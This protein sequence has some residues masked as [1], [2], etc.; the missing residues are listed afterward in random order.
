MTG[1]ASEWLAVGLTPFVL[2]GAVMAALCLIALLRRT[3]FEG[4]LR[5]F[6]LLCLKL[7]T[8]PPRDDA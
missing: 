2:A 7:R 3:P 1:H 6:W 8:Q 5:V 4:E